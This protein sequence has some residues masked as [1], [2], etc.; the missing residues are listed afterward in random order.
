MLVFNFVF[1]LSWTGRGSSV[2]SVAYLA[3]RE[4]P[5][6]E[7]HGSRQLPAPVMVRQLTNLAYRLSLQLAT[8]LVHHRKAITFRKYT[9]GYKVQHK[10]TAIL[11][12][13]S[14]LTV[15]LSYFA[16]DPNVV[17]KRN[18]KW[19]LRK[20]PAVE[21]HAEIQSNLRHGWWWWWWWYFLT[22]FNSSFV[23]H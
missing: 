15:L 20:I 23:N 1:D 16:M 13:D 4:L 14:R 9:T 5:D 8:S 11:P 18:S 22:C 6:S 19:I 21:T 2:S 7:Q 3:C 17:H 10:D 12:R